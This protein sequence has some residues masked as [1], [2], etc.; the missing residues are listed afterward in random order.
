MLQGTTQ[1]VNTRPFEGGFVSDLH[2]LMPANL[3][4]GRATA[5]VPAIQYEKAGQL[6]L[7]YIQAIKEAKDE[8]WVRWVKEIFKT[9]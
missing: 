5:G 7:Q 2:L 6:R 3:M 8:F 1:I 9:K 4:M